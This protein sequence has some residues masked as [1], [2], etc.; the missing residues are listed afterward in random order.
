MMEIEG[1]S[2]RSHG[3]SRDQDAV[4]NHKKKVRYKAATFTHLGTAV[5]NQ[6]CIHEEM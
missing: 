3:M 1:G 6:N 4:Q 2:A 5:A